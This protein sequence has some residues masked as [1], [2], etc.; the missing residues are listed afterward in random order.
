MKIALA[1]INTTTGDFESNFR[2]ISDYVA[3]AK[4]EGADFALF[5]ELALCGCIPKDKS[6]RKNF[7]KSN[8]VYLAKLAET[9]EIPAVVG[10]VRKSNE[11]IGAYNSLAWIEPKR[12]IKFYDKHLL[13]N[14][15][16]FE[17]P[18]NFDVGS[19]V[20]I[21]NF[22]GAKIGLSICEDIWALDEATSPR[23]VK[24][25]RL[26]DTLARENLDLFVNASASLWSPENESARSGLLPKVAKTVNAPFAYC[27][28]IGGND[29]FVCTGGS[30][31]LDKSGNYCKILDKFTESLEL[32]DLDKLS[33]CHVKPFDRIAE[34]YES[35]KMS[36][37]D[38]VRKSGF[39]RVMLGLSG[40]IDSA[41]VAAL[42]A[43]ALGP[44]NVLGFALPSKYSSTH[45][46]KD[47]EDLAKNLG[48]KYDK[49]SIAKLVDSAEEAL[50]GVFAGTERD[51]TEENIQ[52]RSR[53]LLL[54]AISNKFGAMLLATGNKSECAVGYCTLYG[55]TCGGFAP[56]S[57]VYKTDVYKLA[58]Y[59]NR[60]SEII[61]I[62]SILKPPSAELRPD[63]KDSDSLP[64]YSVLD[65]VLYNYIEGKKSI[66]EIEKMGFDRKML[67]DVIRKF[68]RSEYKRRQ[69]PPGPRVSTAS[70]GIGRKVALTDSKT[71]EF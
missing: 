65:A 12:E 66:F 29:E 5:P 23:Y 61:P 43:D 2:K 1:Q 41:F 60:D 64:D 44:E 62:N 49:I 63:Q 48:I 3:R 67:E 8:E 40:G 21:I 24:S 42:A 54:M 39:K 68:E 36:L 4:N 15:G 9:I 33:P 10:C 47:A 19:G 18:R 31:V 56:I 52:S 14:Y 11:A 26:V 6:A 25:E 38:F 37:R 50:S 7:I 28:L 53:G 69:L 34:L 58:K 27:N 55:D 17:E 20:C 59:V 46:V 51:L 32:V 71:Y 16:I 13:P 35:L 22:K 57:D 30:C 70:F 45:S